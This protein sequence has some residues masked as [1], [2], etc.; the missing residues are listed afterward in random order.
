MN[1]E[2]YVHVWEV[3]PVCIFGHDWDNILVNKF[4]ELDVYYLDILVYL[5]QIWV[6]YCYVGGDYR[7]TPYIYVTCRNV[8]SRRIVIVACGVMYD[9]RQ[10]TPRGSPLIGAEPQGLPPLGL[11]RETSW[12]VELGRGFDSGQTYF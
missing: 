11:V 10:S 3:S 7:Y 9:I 1:M 12:L 2:I 6:W 8:M 4:T 5:W